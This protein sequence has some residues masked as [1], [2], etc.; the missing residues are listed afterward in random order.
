MG[1]RHICCSLHMPPVEFKHPL[2]ICR[3]YLMVLALCGTIAVEISQFVFLL[4]F[5]LLTDKRR[6]TL[7]WLTAAFLIEITLSQTFAILTALDLEKA[8]IFVLPEVNVCI[9]LNV[10]RYV[11]GIIAPMFAF[12][13]F[14]IILTI[15][16]G[17]ARPHQ[18]NSEVLA[19][20]YNDG[21]KFFLGNTAVHFV[22][23]VTAIYGPADNFILLIFALWSV[24]SAMHSRLH[25]KME[26]FIDQQYTLS[27]IH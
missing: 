10:P 2:Q 6:A 22:N 11:V 25:F 13:V 1:V 8:F 5:Y 18:R 15:Y 21:A 16:D 17:L 14:I 24:G 3:G 23:F 12:D 4:R 19:G 26:E 20:L 9:I 7:Y 27:F